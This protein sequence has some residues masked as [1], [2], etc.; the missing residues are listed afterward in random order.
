MVCTTRYKVPVTQPPG[1]WQNHSLCRG[2]MG[3]KGTTHLDYCTNIW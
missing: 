1:F 2:Y 3:Y